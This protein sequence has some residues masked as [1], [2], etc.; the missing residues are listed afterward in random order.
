M[1]LRARSGN[2][3]RR[4]SLPSSTRP[5]TST[6]VEYRG[7]VWVMS[8]SLRPEG[9]HESSKSPACSPPS[10]AWPR[11]SYPRCTARPSRTSTISRVIEFSV[12][13]QG[14]GLYQ[15][16][17][18]VWELEADQHA[19]PMA[20]V[21]RPSWPNRFSEHLGDKAFGLLR[22]GCARVLVPRT[23]VIACDTTVRVR[24]DHGMRRTMG[25]HRAATLCG[26]TI[27]NELPLDGSVPAA[28]QRRSRRHRH[29]RR[30]HPRGR[31]SSLV[32]GSSSRIRQHPHR[33]S[34][35]CWRPIH[36][37]RNAARFPAG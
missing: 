36:A 12:H 30:P 37:G 23:E 19:V 18:V 14:V 4:A 28:R 33:G 21:V 5:S 6:T 9:R 29:R 7:S 11:T 10:S 2:L 16:R 3:P 25:A 15:Q 34:R 31:S 17:V 35:R 27:H 1:K 24:Y 32:G 22:R 20:H 26:R 13:P 8:W